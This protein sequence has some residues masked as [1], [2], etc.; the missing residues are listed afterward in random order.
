MSRR[1]RDW[2]KSLAEDLRDREFAKEFLL[3]A[4]EEGAS[5]QLALGKVI[6]AYGLKEFSKK[7]KMASPNVLRIVDPSHNPTQETLNKLLKPFGLILTIAPIDEK[8]AA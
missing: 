7:V 3:A 4:T 5:L 8:K 6:R 2:N 1:S